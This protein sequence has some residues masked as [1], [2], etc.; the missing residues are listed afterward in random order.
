MMMSTGDGF[1]LKIADVKDAYLMAP[2]KEKAFII[3]PSSW[4]EFHPEDEAWEL[5][6]CLPGQRIGARAWHDHFIDVLREE[7]V[8]AYPGAPSL[9]RLDRGV[10]LLFYMDDFQ[11][12][13]KVSE[14]DRFFAYKIGITRFHDK[15]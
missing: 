13:G 9:F 3:P 5:L 10:C 2:Q 4:K 7:K 6:F 15:H 11:L 1:G 14:I 12:F 8:S